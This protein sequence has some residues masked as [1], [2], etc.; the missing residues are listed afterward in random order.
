MKFREMTITS[1][2]AETLERCYT[3]LDPEQIEECHHEAA[4]L[5]AA[6]LSREDVGKLLVPTLANIMLRNVRV[7]SVKATGGASKHPR[8]SD[9]GPNTGDAAS[10]PF[11]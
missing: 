4:E 11:L 8:R 6:E 1:K 3:V 7:R 2:E 5:A 9:N 10:G